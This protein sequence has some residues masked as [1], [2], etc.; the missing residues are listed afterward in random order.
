MQF[1]GRSLSFNTKVTMNLKERLARLD[2][3][4]KSSLYG[5]DK[6][7]PRDF[8]K[9]F[10]GTVC[11][12]SQGCFWHHRIEFDSNYTHGQFLLKDFLNREP[13]FL[14]FAAKDPSLSQL[15]LD[16]LLFI[17]T[18]TTGLSGGVGTLAF[19]IGVGYFEC[20]RFIIE[21]FFLRRFEEE[22]ALLKEFIALSQR[23]LSFNGALV[24]FNGKSYDV[25]LLSNRA[26]FHRLDITIR[27]AIFP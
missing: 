12:N 9:L 27:T 24:S 15:A 3:V 16:R 23:K 11:Q 14:R 8:S 18:E 7:S 26:V 19:I 20:D 2:G 21:Q 13:E 4:K 6:P 25:P 17:D 22:S 5:Q 10:P 1:R